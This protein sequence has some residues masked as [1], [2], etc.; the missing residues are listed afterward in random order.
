M[1]ERFLKLPWDLLG[2]MDL[3]LADKVLLSYLRDR[4]ND[5]GVTWPG[6]RRIARELGLG[7]E[8]RVCEAIRRLER[9]GLL[10]V[11]RRDNGQSNRYHLPTTAPL[12]GAV[13][14]DVADSKPRPKRAQGA[15]KLGAEPR[16]KR[17]HNQTDLRP[18]NNNTV[19]AGD[20][21]ERKTQTSATTAEESLAA[22]WGRRWSATVGGGGVYRWERGKDWPTLRRVLSAVG[23]DVRRAALILEAYLHDDNPKF[24]PLDGHP[25][26]G[27]TVG[28]R[29]NRYVAQTAPTPT[30]ATVEH[31]LIHDARERWNG[32]VDLADARWATAT[33]DAA[34]PRIGQWLR[35]AKTAA[36]FLA[37]FVQRVEANRAN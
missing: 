17:A 12:L 3:R 15:P 8:H 37:H 19:G 30:A 34:N 29:L 22:A 4:M 27:L 20:A 6:T 5:K 21:K 1:T 36:D 26:S 14:A 31:P 23:G 10:T 18:D 28:G 11:E 33:A 2:R 25:L 7:K 35:N 24:P 13:P 16:P 32:A 9:A